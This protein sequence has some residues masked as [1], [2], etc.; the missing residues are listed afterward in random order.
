MKLGRY[1]FGDAETPAELAAAMALRDAA[2]GAGQ[3]DGF[4]AASRHSI[5]RESDGGRVVAAL[6]Y[7]LHADGPGLL[8][9]YAAQ[10]YDLAGLAGQPGK[11]LEIGRLCLSPEGGGDGEVLRLI[12]A[13]LTRIV[14]EG[15]VRVLLGCASFPARDLGALRASLA[16]AARHLGPCAF[17]PRARSGRVAVLSDEPVKGEDQAEGLRRMPPLLRFYLTMGG[18]VGPDLVA[19]PALGSVLLF[20]ALETGAVPPARA[21]A[22]RLLAGA[23][24]RNAQV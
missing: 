20:T 19:D 24:A 15:G 4:D 12:W 16:L 10:F 1:R 22:L 7:S 5:V 14:D 9:G 18:W 11:F 17:A 2:F 3:R 8:R 23:G 13:G 21:R 6:R